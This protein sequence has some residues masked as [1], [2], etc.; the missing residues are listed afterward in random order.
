MERDS[1]RERRRKSEEECKKSPSVKLH[2]PSWL[3]PQSRLQREI[4]GIFA[5]RAPLSTVYP[6]NTAACICLCVCEHTAS[7]WI[8]MN[9]QRAAVMICLVLCCKW[10][11]KQPWWLIQK[12]CPEMP[13]LHWSTQGY[14]LLDDPATVCHKQG[15]SQEGQQSQVSHWNTTC[16]KVYSDWTKLI[17]EVVLVHKKP[18]QRDE[19]VWICMNLL[20]VTHTEAKQKENVSTWVKRVLSY[21]SHKHKEIRGIMSDTRGI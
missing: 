19:W 17:L 18:M 21:P 3:F 15:R 16:L 10:D 11:H 20:L 13:V 7:V 14:L 5:V 9:Q 2:H 12:H 8:F 6:E 1:R 4:I